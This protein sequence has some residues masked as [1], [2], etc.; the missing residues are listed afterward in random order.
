MKKQTWLAWTLVVLLVACPTYQLPAITIENELGLT[1]QS[2]FLAQ[3]NTKRQNA[4][5]SNVNCLD[6]GPNFP[7]KNFTS[8]S[9]TLSLDTTLTKAA[10]AHINHM[11]RS[12]PSGFT[13]SGNPN[14]LAFDP[15]NKAGDGTPVD[16]ASAAGFRGSAWGEV[17]AFDFASAAEVLD[18][19]LTSNFGHCQVVMD[20][21]FNRAGI[22][23]VTVPGNSKPYWI[24]AV[25]RN[26]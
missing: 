4:Q 6:G 7:A 2:A 9:Q 21:D 17:M 18:K 12:H 10:L 16:R 11:A 24:M 20:N 1:D 19:W 26:P 5:T 14:A 15:H 23:K 25:G 3:I 22:A 8:N 13:V